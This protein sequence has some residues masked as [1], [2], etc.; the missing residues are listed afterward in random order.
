MRKI[1]TQLAE[2]WPLVILWILC[3]AF[4]LWTFARCLSHWNRS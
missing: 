2:V 4:F 3:L 1:L